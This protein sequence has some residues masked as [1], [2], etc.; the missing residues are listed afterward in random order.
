[1]AVVSGEPQSLDSFTVLMIIAWNSVLQAILE[2]DGVDYIE[3]DEQGDPI[4]IDERPKTKGTWELIKLALAGDENRA[5]R[6]NLDFLLKLRHHVEHRYL[7]VVD[8]MAVEESQALLL[9][10]ETVISR[11]FGDDAALGDQL[12]VPLRL[13]TLRPDAQMGSLRQLQSQVPGMCWLSCKHT[14]LTCPTM[15][16]RI[17]S[18]RSP[19]SLSQSPQTESAPLMRSSASCLQ[20]RFPKKWMS[21]S[22]R[23]TSSSNDARYQWRPKI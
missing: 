1:V 2:R 10:L 11:E 5:I 7:P 19:S 16:W 8:I 3:T 17:L 18:T 4:S 6:F 21:L 12:I 13:S 15:S 22:V 23:S 20:V 14:D 9:N